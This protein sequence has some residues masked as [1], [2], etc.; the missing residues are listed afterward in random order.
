MEKEIQLNYDLA[1]MEIGRL[2]L[3]LAMSVDRVKEDSIKN[4]LSNGK[5]RFC[6]T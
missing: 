3:L 5:Y 2:A 1:N 6:I 4:A